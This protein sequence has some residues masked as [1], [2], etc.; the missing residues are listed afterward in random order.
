[1]A[2]HVVLLVEDNEAD[3]KLTRRAFAKAGFA[4][5]LD[6]VADGVEALDYLHGGEGKTPQP[7]PDVVLLD[8]N[9]PR[10]SGHEV[11]ERIRATQRTRRLP[12]VVLT[13]SIEEA[14]VARSYDRG[15]NSYVRKPVAFDA[16]V[17]ATRHMGTYW[18]RINHPPPGSDTTT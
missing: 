14:D 16:F 18:L 13:S 15:A 12:V 1:M 10:L 6:V 9:L 11:L 7:L 8:L 4:A 5:R 17:E 3:V 2:D